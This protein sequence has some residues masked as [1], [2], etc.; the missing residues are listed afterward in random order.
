MTKTHKN[1][2]QCSKTL[3]VITV[4]T[5]VNIAWPDNVPIFHYT[6]NYVAGIQSGNVDCQ[7]ATKLMLHF[8]CKFLN[9]CHEG[10]CNLLQ[11]IAI[12]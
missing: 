2:K 12:M 7:K 10:Q 5:R 9:A 8:E 3:Q 4:N 6:F 1:R 11:A